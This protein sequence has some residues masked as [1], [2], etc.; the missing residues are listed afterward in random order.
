MIK[1][2]LSLSVFSAGLMTAAS[3]LAQPGGNNELPDGPGK[4]LVEIACSSCHGLNVIDRSAGYA[5]AEDWHRV[6]STMVE[7]PAAQAENIATYLATH[8]PEDTSRR[9]TL[10]DG[11]LD[12]DIIEWQAPT[13]SQRSRDPAEAPDGSIW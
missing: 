1:H 6:F 4:D 7:L 5:S 13:L 12:I 8:C 10:V 9:P 3:A 2:W 11:D